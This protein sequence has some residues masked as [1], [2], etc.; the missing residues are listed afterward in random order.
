ME[1]VTP[2]MV[3]NPRLMNNGGAAIRPL[4]RA[5]TA[6][7][8]RDSTRNKNKALAATASKSYTEYFFKNKTD[9][10]VLE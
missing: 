1:V 8:T 2:V 7:P 3:I 5:R 9:Q 6:R 4:R 10:E